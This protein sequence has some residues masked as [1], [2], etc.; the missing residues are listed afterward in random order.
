MHQDE[1]RAKNIIERYDAGPKV[2]VK[3]GA[4]GPP[5]CLTDLYWL[6]FFGEL[7]VE[8]FG[9]ER[10][11]MAP[12][13]QV[14]YLES[15]VWLATA[16]TPFDFRKRDVRVRVEKINGFLGRDSFFD[17]NRPGGPYKSPRFD[18]SQ[19]SLAAAHDRFRGKS[20]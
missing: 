12:A 16:A 10:L 18:F 19:L 3:S 9:L 4:P 6:N 15:G 11:M 17:R 8:F 13:H 7:Y 20:G 2:K 1:F 5:E 14:K